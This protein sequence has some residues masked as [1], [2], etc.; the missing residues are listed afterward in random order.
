MPHFGNKK[1]A[2]MGQPDM[3]NVNCALGVLT[4]SWITVCNR[5][6]KFCKVKYSPFIA[7]SL[8]DLLWLTK[9]GH[10][11]NAPNIRSFFIKRENQCFIYIFF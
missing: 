10:H 11:K 2:K 6:F 3:S 9:L 7:Q 1:C 5:S 4:I 8:R